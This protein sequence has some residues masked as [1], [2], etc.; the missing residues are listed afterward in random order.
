MLRPAPEPLTPELDVIAR[1]IVDA[2]FQVHASMGPGLLESV[3][4]SCLSAELEDHGLRHVR[5]A[6]IPLQ[7]KGRH[8]EPG[9]RA[10]LIVESCV[11]VELKSVER[12]HAVHEAQV[13]SYLKLTGL[14]LGLLLN[15]NV[16]LIKHGIR[17]IVL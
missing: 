12:L 9:L 13:L 17:R 11:L 2:A 5:Q 4:E 16:A 6:L 3:Y 10:D 14:R 1:Q 8:I 7:Y 15:F